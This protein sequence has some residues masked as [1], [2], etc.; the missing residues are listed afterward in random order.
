MKTFGEVLAVTDDNAERDTVIAMGGL[1]SSCQSFISA[2]NAAL[3]DLADDLKVYNRK[4]RA[5]FNRPK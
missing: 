2:V 1:A 3:G 4:E 5:R